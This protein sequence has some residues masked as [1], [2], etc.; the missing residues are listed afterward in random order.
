[1]LAESHSDQLDKA[2]LGS[3]YSAFFG[4]VLTG[5]FWYENRQL[6][7]QCGTANNETT[8]GA[9]PY[10]L[11]GAVSA[12]GGNQSN[13]AFCDGH[14]KAMNP[15]ATIPNPNSPVY[16]N[17]PWWLFGEYDNGSTTGKPSM[18]EADHN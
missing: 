3:N 18:W 8:C 16:N 4:G 17:S 12:H 7:N 14:T 1:M 2:G 6:P 5:W 13:F 15:A 11:N 10:G 9:F